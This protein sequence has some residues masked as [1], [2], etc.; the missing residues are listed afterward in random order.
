M[1]SIL[2]AKSLEEGIILPTLGYRTHG[3]DGRIQIVTTVKTSNKNSFLNV[4]TGFGG[5]N[6]ATLYTKEKNHHAH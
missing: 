5:V 6:A 3:V 4:S 2:G 1:N